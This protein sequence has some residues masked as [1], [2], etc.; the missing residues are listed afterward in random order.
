MDLALRDLIDRV[1]AARASA[2]P[3]LIRGGA[4]KAF[5]GAADRV[6]P[7]AA[8][9][10]DTRTLRGIVSY[11]PSE[12]V[13]TARAGTP[14]AELEAAL[15]ERQQ[16]LPFEPPHFD[17]GATVGGMV[18]AGLSGPA[19]ASAGS[20][21]DHVLGVEMVNG[22]GQALRFGGQVMKNVAGYDVSRLLVG[23]LGTL[24]VISEVSLK[25]LPRAPAEC[26]LRIGCDERQALAYL[27]TWASQP[28]PIS[29]CNALVD[30]GQGVLYLRLR[31]AAAAVDSAATRLV[32]ETG[33]TVLSA[34][35]TRAD[36]LAA[37]DLRLPWFQ[38]GWARGQDL[39]R[40][41][42]PPT[43]PPLGLG[44][45]LVDWLGAQRWLWLAPGDGEAIRR[46]RAATQ[47]LGG[48]A[49]L[50]KAAS[51]ERAEASAGASTESSALPFEPLPP[52][53]A[54]LH[55]RLKAEFDPEGVFN[56]GR[57]FGYL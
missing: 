31:G 23:S 1:C 46:V 21:R 9:T 3:L 55:Q 53:L 12:L 50:F 48:H 52:V 57:L 26:S 42:L 27:A 36:W 22:R 18:A 47:A 19:R 8:Q 14:L 33:A 15:A 2:Q 38:S 7:E 34:E 10:L 17:G 49:S 39:W 40:V 45:T 44:D 25:V 41:S 6:L 54:Q 37:R 16:C 51:G 56:P 35:A 30:A 43:A 11:E 4:S 28:L 20:V 29:A 32:R 5:Y 24:G 13:I